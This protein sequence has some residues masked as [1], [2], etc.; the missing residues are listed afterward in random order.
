[1]VV[2]GDRGPSYIP[3]R[4]GTSAGVSAGIGLALAPVAL[5]WGEA[6]AGEVLPT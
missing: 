2:R 4:V 3:E 1:M 5:L 6:A